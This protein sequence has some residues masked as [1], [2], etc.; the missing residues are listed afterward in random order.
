MAIEKLI[1]FF[2]AYLQVKTVHPNPDY[3]AVFALFE[4]QALRDGFECSYISL[5]SLHKQVH[6][7][8]ERKVMVITQRGSDPTLPALGLNHH[9]D[10]VPAP[11]NGQWKHDPF[12]GILEDE[13]LYGRGTQDMKGV[14]VLHYGALQKLKQVHGIPKRTVHILLVPDE[15][16]GGFSGVGQLVQTEE[17]KKLNIGYVLDEGLPSSD[18]NIL[19]IRLGERK[20]LQVSFRCMGTMAH[21]SRLDTHNPV[22]ELVMFLEKI[23]RFQDTQKN[24]LDNVQAG[25]LLSMNVTSLQAGIMHEG[26]IAL[27]VIPEQASATADIRVPPHM[28]MHEAKKIIN[29]WLAGHSTISYTIEAE[30]HDWECDVTNKSHESGLYQVLEAV[31]KNH[32]LEAKQFVSEGASDL[33]FYV[34]Q[35]IEGFGFTPFTIQENL[36]G[37]N[38]SIRMYDIKLGYEL[39]YEILKRFCV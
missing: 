8:A 17:F 38:E 23:A 30:V 13:M 15:E 11:D 20:P 7:Q 22:H 29:D 36:H 26:K 6:K 33:R 18:E 35:G 16:I 5:P 34:Q 1:T 12:A 25:L 2:R 14:G 31:I 19:F 28:K 37:I 27:N 24:K 21:G 4:K 3:Q 9:M 39:F 10:V 32:G